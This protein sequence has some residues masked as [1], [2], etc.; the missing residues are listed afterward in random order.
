MKVEQ[1]LVAV[2]GNASRLKADGIDVPIAKSFLPV[3]E[4]PLLFWSLSSLALAGVS[5][6]VLAGNQ[7]TTP[8]TC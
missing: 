5:K 8:A 2:G 6:L 7:K 4:R 1:A 3:A